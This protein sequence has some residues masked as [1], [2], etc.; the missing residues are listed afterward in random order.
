MPPR[1]ARLNRRIIIKY[2]R[3]FGFRMVTIEAEH[4][5]F[6]LL[7]RRAKPARYEQ[8]QNMRH[9]QGIQA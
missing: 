8:R 3:V 9:S 6:F 7:Y 2:Y 5:I 4:S 1:V